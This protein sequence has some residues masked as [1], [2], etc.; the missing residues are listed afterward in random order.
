MV[1]LDRRLIPFLEM[2]TE[3]GLDWLAFE[4][5]DGV[6]RGREPEEAP[7]ALADARELVQRGAVQN[8]TPGDAAASV[9][10]CPDSS[11]HG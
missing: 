2:L 3:E 10:T 9:V 5:I 11:D 1:T 7:E 8:G 4:L 6:R